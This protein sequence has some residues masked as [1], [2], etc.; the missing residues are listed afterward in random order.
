[1]L[2][3]LFVFRWFDACVR[4]FVLSARDLL[5]LWGCVFGLL[6][7]VVLELLVVECCGL[8]FLLWPRIFNWV[9]SAFADWVWGLRCGFC[10]YLLSGFCGLCLL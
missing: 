4:W 3:L 7:C 6:F 8:V 9:L 2:L 10:W 5:F 1:M